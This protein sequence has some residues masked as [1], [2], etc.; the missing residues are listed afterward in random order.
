MAQPVNVSELR[1]GQQLSGVHVLLS[2]TTGF[3]GK[4]VLSLLLHRFPDVG[5]I[6]ALIRPG[7]STHARD[8]FNKSVAPSPALRPLMKDH[9]DDVADFL[10]RKVVPINGNIVH[11]N[12]GLSSE[13]LKRL[14]TEGVDVIINS[15]GLVDFDPPVDQALDINVVGAQNVVA[16]AQ[17]LGAGVVHVS[18]CFVAGQRNGQV[19]EDEP[20]V[21]RVP[22]G[23]EHRQEGFDHRQEIV[24][25]AELAQEV[26][27]RAQDPANQARFREL[28]REQLDEEGRNPDDSKV[29]RSAVT[30]QR[31]QWVNAELRRV[32]M[33]RS[34]FWGWTNT[35]TF[36]KSLG[37]QVIA[38]AANRGLNATIVRPAIVESAL[39]FPFPGWNEGLTTSAPL[40]LLNRRGLPHF[41]YGE[42]LILDIIPVDMV[43]GAIVAAA[44]AVLS[45]PHKRVYQV[46]SGDSNPL[47]IKRAIELSAFCGRE[48]AAAQNKS[49]LLEWFKRNQEMVPL[50]Q[51]AF[52]QRSI[53]KYRKVA[54]GVMRAVDT[55]GPDN[56]GWLRSATH[57][58]RELAADVERDSARIEKVLDLFMPFIAENRYVFRADNTRH[59]FSRV[60]SEERASLFFDP[61][62]FVWRDYWRDVHTPGLEK[63]VFPQLER[64]LE[65]GPRQ[66]Y[67]HR[68]LLELF[69][70]AT[71]R[72]RHRVAFRLLT[73]DDVEHLTFGDVRLLAQRVAGFLQQQGVQGDDRVVLLAENRPEWVAAYFGVLWAGA[74][75]VPMD[76]QSTGDEVARVVAASEARGVLVSPSVQE[77]L[78]REVNGHNPLAAITAALWPLPKA[79]CHKQTLSQAAPPA[80]TA[81]LIFTS[82]TTGR[83]KGVM[84]SHRNFTFEASRLA[85]IFS[86]TPNDHVLSVLPLHHTFEFTAG[87]LLPLSR[88]AQVT[89]LGELSPDLLS[90]A[91]DQGVTC[92]IGVPALWQLLKRRIESQLDDAGTLPA[93]VMEGARRVNGMARSHLGLNVG[94]L[95]AYPV[96]RALGGRL[97]YLVSGGSAL[98]QEVMGFFRALGFNLTE[99]YGL[100]ETA[101]VLTVSDPK[102]GTLGSVGRPLA[103]VQIAIDAPNEEGIGEVLA[104]GPNVMQGYWKDVDATEAVLQDGWLRTG[105]LGRLDEAGRLQLA[106]RKKDVIVDADGR[107][108]YPDELEELYA[109]HPH[110]RE[111]SVVGLPQGDSERV[112]ALVVPDLSDGNGDPAALQAE[113]EQVRRQVRDHLRRVGEGQPFHKRIKFL[114]LWDGD[115]PRTATRK[116]KRSEVVAIL[117]RLQ[118]DQARVAQAVRGN[119][120][121]TPLDVVRPMVAALSGVALEQ[122]HSDTRL[123]DLGFDSLMFVELHNSLEAFGHGGVTLEQVMEAETLGDIAGWVRLAP[124]GSKRTPSPRP[125]HRRGGAVEG[126]EAPA[127]LQRLG[128]QVLAWGQ[129]R[130]YHNVLDLEVRGQGHVPVHANF[131]VVA[132]HTSHLD[133]G[134]VKTALGAPGRRLHTLAARDYFFSTPLRQTYFGNFTNLLP[135]ERH[136]SFK[137]SLMRAQSALDRGHNLLIFPEGTRSPDGQL[138][139]FKPS[140]GYLAWATGVPILPV[141]VWGT[142]EAMP[143]GSVLWPQARKVGAMMGPVLEPEFLARIMAGRSKNEGYRLATALVERAVSCLRDVGTYDPEVLLCDLL[144]EADGTV[145]PEPVLLTPNPAPDPSVAPPADPAVV[146]LAKEARL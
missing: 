64:E 108:V 53:P 2:G 72:F 121:E 9:G 46:A 27:E 87:L 84:L 7:V 10:R 21:D 85:G 4:V 112:A 109:D 106:G 19:L 86:L 77:R 11:E 125:V 120:G 48:K 56:M 98:S 114:S 80:S 51:K 61:T 134:L 23:H 145:A 73:D 131:L 38:A 44:A 82:G 110:I 91:L 128:R 104:R 113:R 12:C 139:P 101:P 83:P 35:Y 54:Q 17:R 138:M 124:S 94:P 47:S 111:M 1:V 100:T 93:L 133:A 37:E 90:R 57:S 143:K 92:L 76:A 39:R 50:P 65:K 15:A 88:G 60:P 58:L 49:G 43:A 78:R 74:T 99:G 59:L 68:N 107:N 137:Q 71:H 5:R 142:Y 123:A 36:T 81:S 16:L 34:Q 32:G 116:V 89:Y 33:E 96:H 8:R 140:L 118:A 28:A 13:D 135:I 30:R 62:S 144:R 136:G 66:P 126:W 102:E 22:Q 75:C 69:E 141:Y 105:D 45:G 55:L 6:Y 18:T 20:I 127:P 26:R 31:K 146:A 119:P 40:I 117:K 14:E 103:G 115:L 67:V 79:L 129:R 41:P 52:S 122:V 70:T 132:N 29:L 130:L 24:R 25:L 3:L 42:D 97:R 95:T 63:W